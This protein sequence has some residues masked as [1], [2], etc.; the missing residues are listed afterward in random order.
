MRILG[1]AEY[2]IYL[3]PKEKRDIQKTYNITEQKKLYIKSL[4]Q[5][6]K[7]ESEIDFNRLGKQERNKN[8]NQIVDEIDK[9]ISDNFYLSRTQEFHYGHYEYY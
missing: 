4:R 3:L 1:Y 8:L 5:L 2:S 7:D 6:I 9:L